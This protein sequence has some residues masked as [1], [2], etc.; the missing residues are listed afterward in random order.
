MR[1]NIVQSGD[2]VNEGGRIIADDWFE[3]AIPSNVQ[4]GRDVYIDS[5]Y[6]FAGAIPGRPKDR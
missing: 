6:G 1:K 5:S 3:A 2:L 4:I